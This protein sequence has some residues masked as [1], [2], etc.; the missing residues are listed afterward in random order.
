MKLLSRL[1]LMFLMVGVVGFGAMGCEGETEVG[2][3]TVEPDAVPAG[4]REVPPA[5]TTMPPADT[6]MPPADTTTTPPDT[7]T[8]PPATAPA[9]DTTGAGTPR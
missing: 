5:D 8:T 6:T 1:L 7:G 4:E 9:D 2:E 3:T